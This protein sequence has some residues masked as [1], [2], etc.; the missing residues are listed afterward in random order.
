[1]NIT[2]IKANRCIFPHLANEQ[3]VL[4]FIM[5]IK[6]EKESP[7]EGRTHTEHHVAMTGPVLQTRWWRN[8]SM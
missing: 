5:K 7:Q 3:M 6:E 1:M 8:L 2:Q 4:L